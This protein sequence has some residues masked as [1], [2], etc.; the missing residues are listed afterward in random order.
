[1]G[2]RAVDGRGGRLVL[3]GARVRGDAARRDGAMTERPQE[4]LVPEL[5]LLL[6]GLDVGQGARHALPGVIHGLV[7]D[8]AV[9]RL[10]AIFLVPDVFGRRLDRNV[11]HRPHRRF[12]YGTHAE[13][14][15]RV[16][17]FLAGWLTA[18]RPLGRPHPR[19][20][21]FSRNKSFER[22]ARSLPLQTL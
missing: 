15:L 20:R 13:V 2:D 18:A 4:A 8:R 7:E 3:L 12:K 9:L 19:R 21:S 5:A 14:I 6:G 10:E 22:P 11:R 16:S 1:A 17:L